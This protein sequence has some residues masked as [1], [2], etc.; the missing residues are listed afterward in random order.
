LK[1]KYD[2]PRSNVAFNFNLRR[3]N[4]VLTE[5]AMATGKVVRL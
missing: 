5:L 1:L 3:Y 4:K 2:E